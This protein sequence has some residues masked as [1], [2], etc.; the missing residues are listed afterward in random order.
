MK[1]IITLFLLMTAQGFAFPTSDQKVNVFGWFDAH[2]EDC[3]VFNL[4]VL[5]APAEAPA[6]HKFQIYLRPY[7]DRSLYTNKLSGTL[8][9]SAGTISWE[10]SVCFV[11]PG[12]NKVVYKGNNGI[13]RNISISLRLNKERNKLIFKSHV[14]FPQ[15]PAL[16][17][18]RSTIN[19]EVRV[20]EIIN[21]GGF[22]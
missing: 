12:E 15:E 9:S 1:K 22:G 13:E 19:S 3:Y 18:L 21:I 10:R 11:R 14:E 5:L 6:F 7:Y 8:E 4:V 2:T 20:G 16:H 17:Y